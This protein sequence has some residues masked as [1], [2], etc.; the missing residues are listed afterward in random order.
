M[1]QIY[2]DPNGNP[3][4]IGTQFETFFW[5]KKALIEA[6][7][8]M[9]FMPMADVMSMPKHYGKEIR[10]YHY[11]P[12]LDDRNINDQGIDAAGAVIS[13]S[14]YFI[15]FQN[16]TYSFA[17]EADADAFRDAVNA[18]EASVAAKS[19]AGPWVVTMSKD[20]LVAGTLTETNLVQTELDGVTGTL[21][22]D[23]LQGSGN[24]YGSSKDV[25]TITG[26]LPTLTEVGGRVN[27]VGFT[28]IQRTGTIAKFGFF[29]EFTQES[30]DFDSDEDLYG[31]LS[32]EMVTG[33]TQLTEAVLQADLL[34]GAGTILYTGT[35]VS[36]ITM[37]GEGGNPSKVV[38]DDF[39]RLSIMLDENRTP[40]QSKY[41]S[42]SRMIDT[43]T[44]SSGRVMYIGTEL[45]MMLN[46][47][48]DSFNN[49]A[50]IH[51]HQYADAGSLMNGEIG[52]I[53]Q[54]RII[55]VPEMLHWA[56]AGGAVGTNPGYR[57]TA[58]N[59]DIFPMLVVGAESFTTIGFQTDGK[60]VKFK[61]TTKM[62]GKE[63]ADRTDPYGE[64]GFSSIK[65]YYGTM[66]LRPERLALIK[67]L[68]EQ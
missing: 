1:A 7:K 45:Q 33:A 52:T 61:I 22:I 29:T 26:K 11:I 27:R 24:L 67:T 49:Q 63:T 2:N 62:P 25:G 39:M 31:H 42:G 65:W 8:D 12:L 66:I 37:T 64:T 17:V 19:G 9:Y 15:T 30:F 28:R 14:D 34:A 59:Y 54:F 21:G 41:I 32:R 40:K 46:K 16:L 47:M 6:K 57:A 60:T 10:V 55:V 53:D 20:N 13:I 5:H 38:Y 43:K 56:G 68:A 51:A 4:T 48:E 18:I 44:I 58:D 23:V 36:N 35:A 50:F 3:S